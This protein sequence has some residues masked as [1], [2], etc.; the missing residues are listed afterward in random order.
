MGRNQ[1]WLGDISIAAAFQ[2]VHHEAQVTAAASISLLDTSL[3][4]LSEPIADPAIVP[5]YV[6]SEMAAAD[7]VKVLLSGTGGDEIFGGYDRYVGVN[8]RRRLFTST[9]EW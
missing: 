5:S 1:A 7:G 4:H 3:G 2:T 8:M 9:P 6:L